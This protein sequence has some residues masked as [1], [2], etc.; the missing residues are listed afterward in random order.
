MKL[1]GFSHGFT[2]I[3]LILSMVIISVALVG[4]LL[5]INTTTRFSADPMLFHQAAAIAESY[6]DEIVSKN[7]PTTL[8]CSSSEPIGGRANYA[9]ICDY[10]FIVAG[11]EAPT[12]QLG[13]AVS[14]LEKYRVQI[15]INDT[16]ATLQSLTATASQV[17]RIDVIVSHPNIPTTMY[18][19]YRTHY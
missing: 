19:V 5:A 9:S 18:S 6:L 17:I 7:F 14:G 12:D 1:Q 13:N 8:P 15:G 16:N 2:L 11:G 10:K 4:T 3:E